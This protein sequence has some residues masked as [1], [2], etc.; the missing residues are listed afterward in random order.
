V[1]GFR[2]WQRMNRYVRRGERGIKIVR[3]ITS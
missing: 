2:S 3:R 1:A